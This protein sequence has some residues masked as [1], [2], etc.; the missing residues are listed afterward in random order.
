[1]SLPDPV[2]AYVGIGSNMNDPVLQVAK[3]LRELEELPRTRLVRSSSFYET[4]PVGLAAQS[5]FINAV[6]AIDTA[7]QPRELLDGLLE[8]ERRHGRIRSVKNGP[9]TLDLDILLYGHRIIHEEGLTIP[10]PRLHERAFV[11]EPLLE[12]DARCDIPGLGLAAQ[13]RG[14]VSGQGVVRLD[15]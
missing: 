4:E 5:R 7:L 12:V 11:L 6:A 1:M 9:R 15:P 3:A 8:I 14:N 10:H 13:F 2:I